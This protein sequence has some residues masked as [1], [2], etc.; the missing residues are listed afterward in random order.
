MQNRI[1][2]TKV[3]VPGP[4]SIPEGTLLHKMII[5]TKRLRGKDFFQDMLFCRDSIGADLKLN[6]Y[7]LTAATLQS[8]RTLRFTK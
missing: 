4:S 3:D 5:S 7:K 6:A 8:G 1:I 2:L